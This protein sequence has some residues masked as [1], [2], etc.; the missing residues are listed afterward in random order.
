MVYDRS[1]ITLCISR[2]VNLEPVKA[3]YK[4]TTELELTISCNAA[5]RWTAQ[6]STN[7]NLNSALLISGDLFL[8][9]NY[10]KFM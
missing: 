5:C 3:V 9:P 10:I 1:E 2:T 4:E 6:L 7:Q 8:N